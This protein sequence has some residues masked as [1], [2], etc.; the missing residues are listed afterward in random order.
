MYNYLGIA[1]AYNGE[2]FTFTLG[3]AI[4]T[5]K[6]LEQAIKSINMYNGV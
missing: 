2:H 1:I 5:V 4:I 3:K 6:S